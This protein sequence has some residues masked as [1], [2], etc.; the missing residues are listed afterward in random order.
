MSD[1]LAAD[2]DSNNPNDGL[3]LGSLISVWW[4]QRVRIS[5]HALAVLSVAVAVLGVVYTVLP[6]QQQSTVVF[7]LLFK[8]AE[9]GLYPNGTQFTPSDVVTTAV[10]EEVYQR[11]GLEK[12]CKF[13][14]FKSAVVVINRN[15]DIQ[16]LQRE[17]APKL[18]DRKLLVVERQKLEAEYY[19]RMQAIRNGEFTLMLQQ[20]GAL[21]KWPG[22][23]AG[24]VIED[25]LIVWLDQ[26]RSRGVFKFDFNVYSANLLQEI[27]ETNSDYILLLDRLRI[28]ISRVLGNLQSLGQIP[29]SQL[30]RVGDKQV[31]LG[32]LEANL[33][34]NLRFDMREINSMIYSFGLFREPVLTKAYLNEQLFRLEIEREELQSRNKGMQQVVVD[35][36]AGR[37]G[38]QTSTSGSNTGSTSGLM[39]QLSDGFLD[40]ILDLSGQSTDIF[41]RQDIS[42]QIIGNE[43]GMFELESERQ[44][45]QR[46]LDALQKGGAFASPVN[47]KVVVDTRI[48]NLMGRLKSTLENISLLH[49]VLSTRN[50]QPSLAYTIVEPLQQERVSLMSLKVIGAELFLG[51]CAYMGLV[52]VSLA[53]K[54][55]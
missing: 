25:V 46:S 29:G 7:R 14:D 23:L 2:Q 26:S 1:S 50:L 19:N 37:T 44:L 4:R 8:G 34:D 48:A 39:P 53:R 40:R 41:F 36:S 30:V 38:G 16:R 54:Q 33:R 28:T 32:E 27:T 47:I 5:L 45:Y 31:S 13:E 35:Y 55:L 3:D 15:P 51:I 10:L 17:Y 42:R 22:T 52:M 12:F 49:V 6:H 18:E 11:N 21:L 20:D 43:K 24:K 9:K